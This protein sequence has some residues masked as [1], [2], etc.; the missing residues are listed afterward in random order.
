MTW[1]NLETEL[2]T[3][4]NGDQDY[5]ADIKITDWCRRQVAKQRNRDRRFYD[6]TRKQYWRAYF[7]R[8]EVKARISAHN[9]TP[10]RQAQRRINERERHQRKLLDPEYVAKR[11]EQKRASAARRA[12]G[13]P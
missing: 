6:K 7:Q 5:Q 10:E 8:P 12:K 9:K 2:D 11:R 1:D 4:F 13:L 3:L